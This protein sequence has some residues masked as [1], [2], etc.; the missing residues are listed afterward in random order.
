VAPVV[1]G[2]T[3]AVRACRRHIAS[4]FYKLA[5]LNKA[6]PVDIHFSTYC[7]SGRRAARARECSRPPEPGARVK[8]RLSRQ[9]RIVNRITCGATQTCPTCA[10]IGTSVL[11]GNKRAITGASD[12]A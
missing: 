3:P 9:S 2:S 8:K 12:I 7:R 11:Q 5:A 1:P 4:P 6:S 10:S